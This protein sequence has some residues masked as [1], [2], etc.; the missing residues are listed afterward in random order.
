VD[1]VLLRPTLTRSAL[2]MMLM[3]YLVPV[4]RAF[5]ASAALPSAPEN[6]TRGSWGATGT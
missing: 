2:Q 5:S 6:T 3:S 1:A 4:V